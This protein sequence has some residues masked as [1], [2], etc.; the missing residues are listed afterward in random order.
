MKYTNV[1]YVLLPLIFASTTVAKDC[2]QGL[3]YCGSVLVDV[4]NAYINQ[5]R[6]HLY[7]IRDPNYANIS[8]KLF[9]CVGETGGIIQFIKDCSASGQTCRNGGSRQSDFC[10]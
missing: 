1:L 8:Q 3:N 9:Y 4:D 5:T 10:A 2:I 7:D 6:Q